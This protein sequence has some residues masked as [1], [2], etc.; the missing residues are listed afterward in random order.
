MIDGWDSYGACKCFEPV[1]DS[2]E[3]FECCF[4]PAQFA[5][6]NTAI[7]SHYMALYACIT[8]VFVLIYKYDFIFSDWAL[9]LSLAFQCVVLVSRTYYWREFS[10][11]PAVSWE[12]FVFWKAGTSLTPLVHLGQFLY[13]TRLVF[14]LNKGY[15]NVLDNYNSIH[16]RLVT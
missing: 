6:E 3:L 1:P 8:M 14:T 7:M 16:P 11:G 10:T 13:T 2:E 9:T 5:C 12:Q 15:S 4:S